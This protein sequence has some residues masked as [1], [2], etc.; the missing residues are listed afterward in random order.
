MASV[1]AWYSPKR[2][3]WPKSRTA[4]SAGSG[5]ALPDA[6]NIES[7][8]TRVSRLPRVSVTV[9]LLGSTEP[10]MNRSRA[11]SRGA[12]QSPDI[13]VYLLGLQPEHLDSRCATQDVLLLSGRLFAIWP[14]AG[15]ANKPMS[16]T[17]A[18]TAWGRLRRFAQVIVPAQIECERASPRSLD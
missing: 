10:P 13:V 15:I 14:D 3:V 6:R 11:S 16:M 4:K 18:I 9:S 5:V 7:G 8:T 2:T 1:A 12:S 17:V